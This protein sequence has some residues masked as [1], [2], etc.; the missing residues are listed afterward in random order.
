MQEGIVTGAQRNMKQPPVDLLSEVVPEFRR[1]ATEGT[2]DHSRAAFV[3]P[4]PL[5][6]E[7]TD[8]LSCWL[9]RITAAGVCWQHAKQ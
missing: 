9:D 6:S 8:V 3:G 5:R 7:G 2:Y 1:I 4:R